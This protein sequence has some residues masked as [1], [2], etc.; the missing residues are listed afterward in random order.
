MKAQN[1]TSLPGLKEKRYQQKKD[2]IGYLYKVG[3]SSKPEICRFT[4]MTTPTISRII[5]ELIEEGWVSDQG[6]GASIGGKRPHIFS[7]NPDAAYVMGIDLGREQLKIAIFN[8]RKEIIGDIQIYPSLLEGQ[9]NEAILNDLKK[10]VDQTLYLLNIPKSKIK[11]TGLCLPGLIDSDGNS[12]TY[13]TFENSNIRRELENI[14]QIPVFV[15]N[16]STVTAMAEHAFGSA[17]GVSNVLCIN[18][19]ECIGMGMILNSQPYTGCK[20]MAGE[21]GHIRISGPEYPC[22]CG[23]T[24]CLETVASGRSMCKTAREAI[25]SGR[26]TS[27]SSRIA[28]PITLASIIQ[29][30]LQDDLFAIELLQN[31]GKKVGEAISTLIHLF[32]P[33]L[34]VIGG[35]IT[36]AGELITAPIRQ[37]IDKFAFTRM[38]NQCEIRLST[39]KDQACILGT[40]TLVMKQ[41]YYDANSPFSLY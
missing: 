2:I 13:L 12:Y 21:F 33:E 38:K 22:Y 6:Q 35:E 32:N 31:T 29:A 16:D 30:A 36:D 10:N 40:L 39:L 4:N 34:I 37:A 18:I 17:R 1:K 9:D 14:L 15:D 26:I 41:L 5:D 23:K 24:G 8:L 25:T 11:V 20:G 28:E 19:N 27:F 7:L 3:E